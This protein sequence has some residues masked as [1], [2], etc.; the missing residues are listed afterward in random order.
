MSAQQI[1]SSA[2]HWMSVH[3]HVSHSVIDCSHFVV[4]VLQASAAPGFKYI[5]ADDFMHSPYFRKVDV[6]EAGDIV[7]WPGH[8]A[9]VIDPSTG[10][11]IGSQSS[12]GVDKSSYKSNPYW[13]HRN[14][15]TFL[16]YT[17]H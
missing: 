4:A 2:Q 16:R 5:T 1:A 12:T 8:V 9:I 6:P 14:P 10:T 13:A 11:F 3:G 15:R 17:G 7:H